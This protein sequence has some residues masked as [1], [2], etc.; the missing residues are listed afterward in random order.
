MTCRDVI[1]VLADYLAGALPARARRAVESQLASCDDCAR[2]LRSYELTMALAR[3]AYRPASRS[4]LRP[5]P[6]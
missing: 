4:G 6:T 5:D 1:E 2:Y 3:D